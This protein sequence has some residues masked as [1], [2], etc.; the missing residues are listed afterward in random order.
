MSVYLAQSL[1]F[2]SFS[3]IFIVLHFVDKAPK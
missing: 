1:V 3:L 2:A